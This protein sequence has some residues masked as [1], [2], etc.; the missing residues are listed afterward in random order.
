MGGGQVAVGPFLGQAAGLAEHDGDVGPTDLAF[1]DPVGDERGPDPVLLEDLRVAVLDDHRGAGQG[2]ELAEGV[3]E[4]A[5]GQ[6]GDQV[7][8]GLAFHRGD[9]DSVDDDAVVPASLL[10]RRRVPRFQMVPP[11][12]AEYNKNP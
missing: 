11:V 3:A 6:T 9:E 12:P 1:G 8:H 5:A 2:G 10:I 7:G 4:P